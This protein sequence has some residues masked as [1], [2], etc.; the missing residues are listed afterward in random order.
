[1]NRNLT[2]FNK[3]ELTDSTTQYVLRVFGVTLWASLSDD[4]QGWFRILGRGLMWKHEDKG[5]RFSERYGY[6]KFVKIGKW[7]IEYLPK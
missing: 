7:I 5:L 3:T 2:Y 6:T 1:M 4:K